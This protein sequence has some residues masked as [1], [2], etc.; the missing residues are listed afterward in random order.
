MHLDG[1]P[2]QRSLEWRLLHPFKTRRTY[3]ILELL[4]L[5]EAY[6]GIA[7]DI[8]RSRMGPIGKASV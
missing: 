2:L 5:T 8:I 4:C 7:I 1:A 3:S 6:K